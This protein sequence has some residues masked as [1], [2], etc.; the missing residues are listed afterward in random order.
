MKHEFL[1]RLCR[2]CGLRWNVSR[3]EPGE[4]RYV[5]PLH[6]ETKRAAHD[7]R[8]IVDGK[9]KTNTPVVYRQRGGF[10]KMGNGKLFPHE[11]PLEITQEIAKAYIK[12]TLDE[13]LSVLFQSREYTVYE[14]ITDHEEDV[15]DFVLGGGIDRDVV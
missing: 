7:G 4:K 8:N 12:N 15:R 5:C 3:K 2:R 14:Y 1:Y 6:G 11:I 9:S 13:F 10:V